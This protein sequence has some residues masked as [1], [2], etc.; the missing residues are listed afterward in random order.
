[1]CE[2]EEYSFDGCR[3]NIHSFSHHFDTEVLKYIENNDFEAVIKFMSALAKDEDLTIGKH[4]LLPCF[5]LNHATSPEMSKLI[6][7]FGQ[8]LCFRKRTSKYTRICLNLPIISTNCV[9]VSDLEAA[10]DTCNLNY[11]E[12]L[13][14]QRQTKPYS[15][16]T[17]K[18]TQ[19]FLNDVI[20][21]NILQ[22]SMQKIIIEEIQFYLFYLLPSSLSHLCVSYLSF[23]WFDISGNFF[24]NKLIL[25]PKKII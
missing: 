4:V 15:D 5:A 7:D 17:W 10:F 12:K 6:I 21:R 22:N 9:F 23:C 1:M 16:L 14:Q 11:V 3:C 24:L 2:A 19:E 13:V 20:T 8:T 18:E 25:P